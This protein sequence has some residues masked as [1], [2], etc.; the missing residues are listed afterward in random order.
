LNVK[1]VSD[2]AISG[3]ALNDAVTKRSAD[4]VSVHVGAFPVHAPPHPLKVLV[5]V[6]AAV[7]VTDVVAPSVIA[8]VPLVEAF[9]TVQL[10]PPPVTVPL[11]VPPPAIVRRD[12]AV[13]TNVTEML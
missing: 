7:R 13:T 2:S 11:P 10:I 1:D 5:P 3:G 4:I 12:E 8:Q 6:G 9:V